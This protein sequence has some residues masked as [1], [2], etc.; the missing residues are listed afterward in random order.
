ME[1]I[2]QDVRF[3]FRMLMKH[4]M[5]SLVC[6]IALALGIGANAAVFSM[7]EAFLVH[8]V[9]FEN[10][11]R[12]VAL[13]D[14][15]TRESGAGFG[16][17]DYVPIAPA[18]YFDWKKEARSFDQITAYAWDEVNLT[19]D[20][21][22]QKLQAF[23]VPAN[24]FDTIGVHPLMGRAFLPEEEEAGKEQEIILGHALWEQRYAS[25]PNILGKNVKVDGKSLRL[26]DDG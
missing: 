11:N 17:Q 26:S 14:G 15:H 10:G 6:V 21:E 8:P 23:H 16:P 5:V 24:F 19:G 20:R 9:P 18:T 4:R 22:P 25:D 7:A 2:W 13:I 12:I 1:T 3:G